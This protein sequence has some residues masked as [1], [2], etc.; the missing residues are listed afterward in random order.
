MTVPQISVVVPFYNNEDLLGDCLQSIAA[1][2]F[3]DLEVIM[4]D[5]GSSD[6][7][8]GI[9]QDRAASDPRFRLIR[10]KNGGPGYARNRG[11]EHARGEYLAFVD[12]DDMLP[13]H[14]L[15]I[16]HHTLRISGSDFA[17]GNV[18]RIGPAG[19]NQSSLHGRAIKGRRIGMPIR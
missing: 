2:T 10:V 9:A 15:E 3:A 7:S 6:G 5:D 1:Q 17:S 11:I 4:V 13:S 16:L 19:V 18:L 8:A 14:A 12:A